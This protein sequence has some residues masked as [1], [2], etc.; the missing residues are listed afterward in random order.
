[1]QRV[2]EEAEYVLAN[3]RRSLRQ[4]TANPELFTPDAQAKIEKAIVYFEWV[5]QEAKA[6]KAAEVGKAA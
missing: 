4:L 2:V 5:R 3:L 1:M 6:T